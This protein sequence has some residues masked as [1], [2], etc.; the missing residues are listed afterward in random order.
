MPIYAQVASV[1][2]Q[3]VDTGLWKVGSRISAIEDMEQEFG[4][5]RV[6]IRQ[7]ME[8]LK[9]EGI[10]DSKA[11]R[12]TFVVGRPPKKYWLNLANDFGT[13]VDSIRNNI[14]KNVLFLE[15]VAPPVIDRSEGKPA[16]DYVFLRS[17]Q[18]AKG[19]PFAVV[20]LHL[21]KSIFEKERAK[22]IRSVTLAKIIEMEGVDLAHAYQTVTIGVAEPE[23]A[24]LL[25]IE[26]GEPTADCRLVLVDSNNTAIYVASIHYHHLCFSLGQDLLGA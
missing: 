1:M 9:V 14:V 4:V 7:A 10:L 23:T 17:V 8:M 16:D 21:S 2:R 5:A 24:L 3:R 22:I 19:Q 6:T 13:I 12:G 11:G 20:N 25:K 15:Q 18:Y 26:L